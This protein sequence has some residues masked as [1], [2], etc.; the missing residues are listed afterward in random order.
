MEPRGVRSN[1]RAGRADELSDPGRKPMRPE[2][3]LVGVAAV[4]PGRLL[5]VC[6]L[7]VREGP[8]VDVDVREIE[9]EL[10]ERRI[11]EIGVI[12]LSATGQLLVRGGGLGE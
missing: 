1:Q 4:R 7:D 6:S 8:I 2:E 9:E 3:L 10:D 12:Q 5:T 11:V